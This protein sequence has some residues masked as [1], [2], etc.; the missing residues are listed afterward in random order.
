MPPLGATLP[1]MTPEQTLA[2][3]SVISGG[4]VGLAGVLLA[5]L[6]GWRDR[7]HAKDLAERDRKQRRLE[8]AY[9][10]MMVMCDKVGNWCAR[11]CPVVANGQDSPPFPDLDTQILARSKLNAYGS[12]TAKAAFETWM[13]TVNQVIRADRLIG[14][15]LA[16]SKGHESAASVQPPGTDRSYMDYLTPW[17]QLESELRPAEVQYRK[18]LTQVLAGELK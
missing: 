11:V 14:L 17:Q 2:L 9:L 4:A 12:D 18:A 13:E 10:G 6:S 5:G 15:R 1:A 7:K 16:A 3:W 8:D